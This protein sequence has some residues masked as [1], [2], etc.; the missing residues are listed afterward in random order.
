TVRVALFV[1]ALVFAGCA[2]PVASERP[3]TVTMGPPA[4]IRQICTEAVGRVAT[5]CLIREGRRLIVFCPYNDARCLA[6]ELGHA[7][8]PESTENSGSA[9]P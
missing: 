6:R 1:I 7:S 3:I 8:E 4:R 5:G 9:S 2:L